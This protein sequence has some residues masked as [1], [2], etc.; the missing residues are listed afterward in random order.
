MI[1]LKNYTELDCKSLNDNVFHLLDNEWM[2]VTGGNINSYNT[3]TAS[4]GS[5]GI[6]W[7]KPVATIFVRPHRYT[8]E[9]LEK[10]HYFSLSF[11]AP[12]HKEILS[13]CGSHSGRN[14]DKITETGLEVVQLK[15]GAVA[16]EQ[17]RMIMDCKVLYS[18]FLKGED[19]IEKDIIHK[20][21]PSKDFHKM[22]IAEILKVYIANE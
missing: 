13:Y 10:S 20:E 15:S 1:M 19:F 3:M 2:L 5:F 6:L 22:Y 9:F 7:H 8:F 4:W 11:F 21:Y 16:F 17:A 12:E 14:I 18:D